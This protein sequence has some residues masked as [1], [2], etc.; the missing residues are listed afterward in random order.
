MRLAV[1][2]PYLFPY[3]GYYQL[4]HAVDRFIFYDDV[5]F[6]KR[7]WIHRN[8]V[9]VNRQAHR[10]SVPM[11][12]ASQHQRID[13]VR[14]HPTEYPTWRQKFLKTL[15]QS[16]RRAPCFAPIYELVDRVLSPEPVSIASLAAESVTAVCDYLEI[17]RDFVRASALSYDTTRRGAER[18]LA[19]CAQSGADAYVNPPGG[20]DL[21]RAED[22]TKRGLS[23]RF[24]RP[25]PVAYEQFGA[26]FVPN[27]SVIDVL[28]FNSPD[29]IQAML[30]RYTLTD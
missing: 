16:Y 19:L 26:P 8:Q 10:F 22:F 11:D 18:I 25:E 1:M 2:Q 4:V 6:I 20:Q 5:N 28:M 15:Q 3:L 14:L 7:G 12:R 9:L 30:P 21:Y 13:E 23:L 24:I 29:Q 27:L 17:T